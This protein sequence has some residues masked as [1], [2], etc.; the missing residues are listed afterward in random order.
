MLP[1]SD[2]RL[3]SEARH[4]LVLSGGGARGAYEIG[5]LR[6]LLEG[7]SPVTAGVPPSMEIFTGTSVGAYNA[8]FLAQLPSG[9]EAVDLLERIW[10]ER[11]ANT[12]ESCG[13]GVYRLRADPLRA[14]DPGCLRNPL[15]LL[16]DLGRDAVFWSGYALSYGTQLLTADE[17]LRVRILESFNLAALFSRSPL[18]ELVAETID[19]GRLRASGNALSVATSDWARGVPKVL[20]KADITERVGTDAILASVAIPGVFTPVEIDGTPCVDGA[21]FMNTPLLPAIQA[22]ANVIH[23]IYLDPQ[24]IELAIPELPNT[25]DTFY[26]LY[27]IVLASNT[28][29][30]I[31]T[32]AAINAEL[33]LLASVGVIA[34][35][36][37]ALMEMPPRRL[38]RAS[39]VV[40]RLLQGRPY[41]PIEIHRYR[42]KTDLG[43]VAGFLD[44]R[45]GFIAELIEQGYQDALQ[46]DCGEAECVLP[47]PEAAA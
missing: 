42:P 32:A 41:R 33:E 4:A 24:V 10:R 18:E 26:R 38:R 43:G 12:A 22:G 16:A 39:R 13:N 34:E 15:Q 27:D 19:L 7:A 8:A 47:P 3:Y 6:A 28:R 1:L 44:F 46:H 2:L 21:L 17:P 20:D 5:V 37:R 14:L 40:E 45:A 11:I 25:L 29:S 31:D 35:S 23:I 30:D 36:G 9:L